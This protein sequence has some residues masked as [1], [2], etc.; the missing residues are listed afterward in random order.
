MG[1]Y[2]AV[3]RKPSDI[4]DQIPHLSW[5]VEF[6]EEN[7]ARSVELAEI[8]RAAALSP[9]HFHRVFTQ[10]VGCS[11]TD[12]QRD[13]RL[14]EAAKALRDTDRPSAEIALSHGYGSPE[15]FCRAFQRKFHRLPAEFRRDGIARNLLLPGPPPWRPVSAGRPRCLVGEPTERSSP[16][17]RW[18]GYGRSGTNLHELNV[19]IIHKF[20]QDAHTVPQRL[21]PGMW[22]GWDRYLES[23][24]PDGG[25]EYFFGEETLLQAKPPPGMVAI[26]I[27]ARR[28]AVFLFQGSLDELSR[29]AYRHIW[30]EVLPAYGWISSDRVWKTEGYLAPGG[31]LLRDSL[32]IAI[33]LD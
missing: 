19:R 26:D 5:A 14:T 13:R 4:H 3:V 1:R 15:A 33:P 9:F 7:L 31:N 8:A 16:A 27:P 29:I 30:E 17:R 11:A 24:G 22:Q 10:A 12:Y 6:L 28:E 32:E 21:R 25:Y 18:I 23:S 20:I 2:I